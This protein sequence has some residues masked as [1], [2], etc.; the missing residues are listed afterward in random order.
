MKFETS[1]GVFC[2]EGHRLAN[3]S[4]GNPR[5]PFLTGGN[6]YEHDQIN[7]SWRLDDQS[8]CYAKLGG[9]VTFTKAKLPSR[10]RSG[11]SLSHLNSYIIALHTTMMTMTREVARW[12]PARATWWL[13]HPH[14]SLC[15]S[16]GH[17]MSKNCLE[18][19]KSHP[20]S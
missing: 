16:I 15:V 6:G 14:V 18:K 17:P 8:N 9:E 20:N 1:Y 12:R 3:S 5:C 13:T 7:S 4:W 19:V 10:R 11:E 2:L